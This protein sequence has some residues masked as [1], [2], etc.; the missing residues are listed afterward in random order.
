MGWASTY[1]AEVRGISAEQAAQFAALFYIGITIS[2]FISGFVS[3]KLGDRNMIILGTTI[4]IC[5]IVM[6]FISGPN[7]LAVIAFITIGFGC[8]PI[9][10]CIIHSTPYNFGTENSGAI[11]GIQMASAY[12]GTTF[13]PPLFGQLGGLIGFEIMPI[14]LIIFV[15]LMITMTE[16]TFRIT[17]CTR[18]YN[19]SVIL[20]ISKY[21]S[22]TC[23]FLKKSVKKFIML[24]SLTLLIHLESHTRYH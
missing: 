2:R 11:I 18:L 15:V 14:Y 4:V 19:M 20:I 9:Y 5:G 22:C 10:P 13:I 8:G 12:I 24:F 21:R 3:D 23:F 16:L 6:L 7:L 17:S 1:F